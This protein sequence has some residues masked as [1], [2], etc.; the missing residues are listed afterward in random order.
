M[1][2]RGWPT[3]GCGTERQRRFRGTTA[4]HFGSTDFRAL[5]TPSS[6][7]SRI[8]RME[9]TEHSAH[10]TGATATSNTTEPAA[11]P[12]EGGTTTDSF[13]GVPLGTLR[14]RFARVWA[15]ALGARTQG[16]GRRLAPTTAASTTMTAVAGTAGP[17][18]APSVLPPAA[19]P[20][21]A[22]ETTTSATTAAL[23][24]PLGGPAAATPAVSTATTTTIEA[25]QGDDRSSEVGAKERT[26]SASVPTSAEAPTMGR[27]QLRLPGL[28]TARATNPG[29][30][31]FF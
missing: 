22:P 11:T 8:E 5:R 21:S 3:L 4:G 28:P 1:A 25:D 9:H 14:V 29:R 20:A 12:A 30:D 16:T 6:Q 27:R 2:C 26:P 17:S 31:V 18:A 19:P 7:L 10:G 23:A 15:G 13:G 24:A